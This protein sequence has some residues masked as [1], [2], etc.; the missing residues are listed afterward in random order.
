MSRSGIEAKIPWHAVPRQVRERVAQMLG[1]DVVRAARVWGGYGPTPTYRLT[2]ADRCRAFFKAVYASSNEV[3][4]RAFAREER[5]YQD[6]GKIIGPWA[7]AYF[8][9][10]REDDWHAMLLEDLGPKSAPPWTPHLAC[11]VARS[12]AE[13]HAATLGKPLPEWIERNPRPFG[14]PWAQVAMDSDGLWRIAA[15]AGAEADAALYWLRVALPRF[16]DVD[17]AAKCTN[18]RVA[19]VHLDA[20]S[21]NLRC[22]AGRLRLFDWPETAVAAPEYD[23]AELA[24]SITVEGGPEPEQVVAWYAERLPVRSDLLD[25]AVVSLAGFFAHRS[26]QA[27]VR[28]LPRLRQFQRQQLVVCLRWAAR[29]LGLLEPAWIHGIPGRMPSP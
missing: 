5:I 7:P 16:L 21:D 13:F 19:L 23:I 29:R 26:W 24:Q 27:E 20:R 3:A 10:F 2:L 15:L 1:S 8:G 12:F 22:V 18:S 14:P 4:R 11:V 17:G 6:L 9:S 28:G 25:T